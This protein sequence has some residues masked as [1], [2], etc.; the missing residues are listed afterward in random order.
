[1]VRPV[2]RTAGMG[3]VALS[4]T[5][6]PAARCAARQRSE[7][8]KGKRA[9]KFAQRL[10][11]GFVT[12]RPNRFIMNVDVDGVTHRCHCPVTSTIANLNFN[13]EGTRVPCLVSAAATSP[14]RK[15]PFT[16]EA[17]SLDG[18]SSWRGINQTAANRYV[19]RLL[20]EG[21]L[22]ERIEAGAVHRERRLGKSRIDFEVG[23]RHFVEVKT[24]VNMGDDAAQIH[25]NYSREYSKVSRIGDRLI[26]HYQ[27]LGDALL[28][29]KANVKKA[30]F[31]LVF[32]H[33]ASRFQPAIHEVA[34]LPG[35]VG[36]R[37]RA[38]RAT[39]DRAVA[40]GV[41]T[42]QLNLVINEDGFT[43]H[44]FFKLDLFQ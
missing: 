4:R 32:L 43:L 12:A 36:E 25:P 1:M 21:M 22:Q 10:Q 30:T 34:D 37:I 40:A 6:P 33:K 31:V 39:I 9:I 13:L 19:E 41:Q 15:T 29:P 38:L 42:W 2:A 28:D 23:D 8:M 14:K 20:D 18:G 27:E 35:V 16:V 17:I 5:I 26:R 11:R 3:R 44:D 24:L 7:A